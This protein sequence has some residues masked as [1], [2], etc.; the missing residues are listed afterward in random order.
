MTAMTVQ[1]M[2]DQLQISLRY[3]RELTRTG[4]IR[5]VRIGKRH[6]R[7]LPQAVTDYLAERESA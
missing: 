3:A 5:T 6:L 4:Q 2:A 7:V 1:Q